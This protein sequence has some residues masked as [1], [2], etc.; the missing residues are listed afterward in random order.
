MIRLID[1]TRNNEEVT[2]FFIDLDNPN[3]RFAYSCYEDMK[4]TIKAFESSVN[5]KAGKISE[6][7]EDWELTN[8]WEIKGAETRK[9]KD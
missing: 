7:G 5:I 1:Y 6:V 2:H 4:D 3:A 8:G 9:R